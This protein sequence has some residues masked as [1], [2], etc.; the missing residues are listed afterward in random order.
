VVASA[1][2][3]AATGA[4]AAAEAV[5]AAR[6]LGAELVGHSSRPLTADLA[7]QADHLVVMTQGHFMALADQGTGLG[8]RPR[9]L[10]PEG[11]D[12]PDPVGGDREVYRACARAIWGHLEKLV[13]EVVGP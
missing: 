2:L 7:R 1:G 8:L 12:L 9:L 4:E 5:E 6:E 10:C 13:P 11:N 3:A